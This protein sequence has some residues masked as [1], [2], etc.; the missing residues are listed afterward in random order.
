MMQ[1]Q[2]AQSALDKES[3]HAKAEYRTR[4][5]VLV[6]VSRLR[7]FEGLPFQGHMKA[8]IQKG[9]DFFDPF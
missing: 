8:N 7:L 1:R 6:D 4:L 9:K 5:T 3:E 2:S